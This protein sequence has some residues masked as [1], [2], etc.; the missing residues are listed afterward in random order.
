LPEGGKCDKKVK[1]EDDMKK[2]IICLLAF[3][4]IW[5]CA[6]SY[7]QI[8][9]GNSAVRPKLKSD[10]SVYILVPEDG[11]Y[12]TQTYP[13]SGSTAA[14]IIRAAFEKHL[15]RV[16]LA[17]EKESLELAFIKARTQGF[18]YFVR[19][20]ILRWEQNAVQWAGNPDTVE[21]KIMIMDAETEKI[22]DAVVIKDK[23]RWFTVGGDHPPDLLPEPIDTYVASLF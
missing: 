20:M 12:G 17:P 18:T 3:V 22:I 4:F 9:V 16:Q 19:P 1:R 11:K 15:N 2:A 13:G 6:H 7:E 14:Q 23:S 5:G 21:I 10:G 8:K